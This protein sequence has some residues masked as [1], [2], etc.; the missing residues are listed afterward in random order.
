MRERA[1]LC[2]RSQL[3]SVGPPAS[4]SLLQPLVPPLRASATD[5]P[6]RISSCVTA[7]VLKIEGCPKPVRMILAA[8]LMKRSGFF[9]LSWTEELGCNKRISS[10]T[11]R[12]K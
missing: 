8:R 2:R 1:R 6:C 5:F 7:S 11:S 9:L 10:M 4:A 3:P 12:I